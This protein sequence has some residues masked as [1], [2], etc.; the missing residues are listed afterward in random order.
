M[1]STHGIKTLGVVGAGQM[2]RADHS[3]LAEGEDEKKT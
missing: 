1:M 2:V 3:F